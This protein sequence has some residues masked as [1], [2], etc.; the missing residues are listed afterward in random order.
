M[1]AYEVLEFYFHI[2]NLNG[3]ATVE[4][5]GLV[6]T[7]KDQLGVM[8]VVIATAGQALL[9]LLRV[10]NAANESLIDSQTIGMYV[11]LVY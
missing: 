6:D 11:K 10:T 4:G 5:W 9:V 2:N 1:C 7:H 3:S 8:Q